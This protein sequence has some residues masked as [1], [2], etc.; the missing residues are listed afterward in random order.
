MEYHIKNDIRIIDT[1]R[2][3]KKRQRSLRKKKHSLLIWK[4]TPMHHFQEKVCLIQIAAQTIR[5]IDRPASD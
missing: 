4:R 5:L 3:L 2:R 1:S